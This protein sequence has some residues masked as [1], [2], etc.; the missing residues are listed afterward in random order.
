MS[1]LESLVRELRKSKGLKE[2]E[3]KFNPFTP[4]MKAKFAEFKKI[5]QELDNNKGK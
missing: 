5:W 3:D 4:M 1:K 2:Y